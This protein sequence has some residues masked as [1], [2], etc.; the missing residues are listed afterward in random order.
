MADHLQPPAAVLLTEGFSS[1]GFSR[2]RDTG[3]FSDVTV[4]IGEERHRLHALLLARAS[5]FF[6]TCLGSDCFRE[7]AERVVRLRL[8]DDPYNALPLLLDY[9]YTGRLAITGE[10]AGPLLSLARRLM[11][12]EVEEAARGA[13]EA[14]MTPQTCVHYLHQAVRCNDDELADAAVAVAAQGAGN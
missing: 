11:V 3:D 12:P 8:D 13:L 6:A 9:F 14:W 5:A 4:V 2:F 10:T 1:A 7:G